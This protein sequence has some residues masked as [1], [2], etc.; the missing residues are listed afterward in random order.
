MHDNIPLLLQSVFYKMQHRVKVSTKTIIR[1][2]GLDDDSFLRHDLKRF[3]SFLFEKIDYKMKVNI[4]SWQLFNVW[5]SNFFM[6]IV[7][8]GD[9][10]RRDHTEAV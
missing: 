3:N 1:A 7:G 4:F 9:C 5:K 2:C 10:C 8:S 6:F